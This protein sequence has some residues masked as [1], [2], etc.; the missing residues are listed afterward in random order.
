MAQETINQQN[1]DLTPTQDDYVPTW[2]A[3]T[4]T[5][6]KATLRNMQLSGSVV[7]FVSL[8][9]T[10]VASAS[11]ALPYD[12]TIPQNTEG[13]QY[14]TLAITPRSLTNILVIEVVAGLSSAGA[15]AISGALFQDATANALA[16]MGFPDAAALNNN[17]FPLTIRHIMTAGTIAS[18]TFKF[19]AGTSA[20]F[21]TTFNGSAGVRIFGAITK[22]S[23]TI[24]EFKV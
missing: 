23:F 22:S 1:E 7:Q 17:I 4:G 9:S 5:T 14:M 18:T 16:A 12:D 3:T 20:G 15:S 24:T 8:I 19:R 11:T 10:A 2:D 21:T 6:K 13:D